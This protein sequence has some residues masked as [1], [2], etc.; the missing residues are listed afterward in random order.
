M[1][2]LATQ[3]RRDFRKRKMEGRSKPSQMTQSSQSGVSTWKKPRSSGS[4]SSAST[5]TLC[6]KCGR[7]HKGECLSGT[8]TCYWCHQLGHMAKS[9]P[10]LGQKSATDV[11]SGNNAQRTAGRPRAVESTAS[12]PSQGQTRQ[13]VQPRV[14]GLSQQEA[15]GSPDVVTGTLLMCD[16]PVRILFDTGASHFFVSKGF[17]ISAKLLPTF[18]LKSLSVLMPN[19]NHMKANQKCQVKLRICDKKFEAD[20]IVLPLYE[21]D[22]ILGM[23]WLSCH[24][25]TIDCNK[26]EDK[27]S[28]VKEEKKE[29]RE[30]KDIPIV[31]EFAEVFSDDL[32]GLP[33]SREIDF[34]I[35]LVAGAEPVAKAP[36]IM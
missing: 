3:K 18:M 24:F 20:L 14:Y 6:S 30:L 7:V 1:D 17:V 25:V 27:F 8:N 4:D 33:P 34:S 26:K 23:D 28:Y 21:F 19:G 32:L 15:K 9:C 16:R 12:V 5:A 13:N 35:E 36:Y 2:M 11:R 22:A 29:E 31:Q 10:L